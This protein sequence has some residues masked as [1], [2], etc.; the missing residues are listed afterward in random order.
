MPKGEYPATPIIQ[1]SNKSFE[2]V[3]DNVIDYFAQNG[4]PIKIIDKS[5]GLI[6]S[7]KAR[8]TWSFE[9]KKFQLVN[10]AAFVVMPQILDKFNEKPYKPQYVT[11]EWNVRIKAVGDKTTVNVNLYN[12]EGLY[13]EGYYSYYAH[14]AVMPVKIDG[15]TTGV[16][17]RKFFESV[18]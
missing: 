15:R 16:F 11:G 5:S 1:A 2:K 12:I 7:D 3:W 17:E 6:I 14:S 10:P 18:Q 8:L 13:F 4:I 9:N